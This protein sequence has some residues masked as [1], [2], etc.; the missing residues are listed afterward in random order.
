VRKLRRER[1]EL[2][3]RVR[4]LERDRDGLERRVAELRG[5]VQAAWGKLVTRARAFRGWLDVP[6]GL[7][8]VCHDL[9]RCVDGF[10]GLGAGR[11][12]SDGQVQ[13]RSRGMAR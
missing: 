9:A 7:E 3:G 11:W 1:C 8:W 5:H 2:V 10:R 13:R 6:E 4:E 12:G